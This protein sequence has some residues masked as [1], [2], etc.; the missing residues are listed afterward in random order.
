MKTII[1]SFFLLIGLNC[2]GQVKEEYAMLYFINP[3]MSIIP[4]A[5]LPTLQLNNKMIGE[6]DYKTLVKYKMYSEGDVSIISRSNNC[7]LKQ[8]K[9]NI[10]KGKEY[11]FEIQLRTSQYAT[12]EDCIIE[13]DKTLGEALINKKIKTQIE[14]VESIKDPIAEIKIKSDKSG[15]GF[16]IS[17]DGYIITNYH[18][19]QDANNITIKGIKGDFS[20]AFKAN[21]IAKDIS[22]DIALLKLE[23]SI[24]TFDSIP[25]S[26]NYDAIS[27]GEQLFVLGYPLINSMG[28]EI[29]LT[30]GLISSNSG[31]DGDISTYQIS[32]P[33][34]PGNSGG[35]V[36]DLN[37]N[38]IAIVNAKHKYAENASYAIKSIYLKNFLSLV[39]NIKI[40][41]NQNKFENKSLPDKI[42]ILKDYVYIIEAK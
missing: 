16:L 10:E 30:D 36:F 5:T 20:T 13:V 37:G 29:K 38:L 22:S 19:I 42:K 32:A 24:I 27:Q 12:A 8:L 7:R 6:I 25:Y 15:T 14:L 17:K 18:V 26:I 2:F 23:S 41:E 9:V 35:P 11:Y 21:V 28:Q 31:Y 33:V 3:D 1:T 4:T 40:S 34:Q 39:P